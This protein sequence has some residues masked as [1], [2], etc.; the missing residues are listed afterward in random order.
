MN[1]VADHAVPENRHHRSPECRYHVEQCFVGSLRDGVTAPR[2]VPIEDLKKF[3]P[4]FGFDL[5]GALF[6]DDEG[7][8]NR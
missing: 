3:G 5:F 6:E 7:R 1:E 4:G 8:E 2:S